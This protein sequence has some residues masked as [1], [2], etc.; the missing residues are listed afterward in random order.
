VRILAL[1]DQPK[2]SRNG[3]AR[4]P[5]GLTAPESYVVLNGPG[6]SGGEAFAM[7]GGGGGESRKAQWWNK[8]KPVH[9]IAMPY[10]SQAPMMSCS[11]K[12]PPG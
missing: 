6:A 12:P 2:V 7:A 4:D 10:S 11:R 9:T 1:H 5:V 3:L 8:R